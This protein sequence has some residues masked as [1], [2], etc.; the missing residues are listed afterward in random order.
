MAKRRYQV[1]IRLDFVRDAQAFLGECLSDDFDRYD[2]EHEDRWFDREG[3]VLVLDTNATCIDDII[4]QLRVMYPTA[5]YN[6]F[7]IQSSP[8]DVITEEDFSW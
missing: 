5:S 3:D 6:I 2:E 8:V 7:R 4:K 1:F